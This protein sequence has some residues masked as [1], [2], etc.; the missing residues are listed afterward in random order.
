MM[1]EGDTCTAREIL[2][3]CFD[4]ILDVLVTCSCAAYPVNGLKLLLCLTHIRTRIAALEVEVFVQ[5]LK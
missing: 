1:S 2:C 5:E 3:G 4:L